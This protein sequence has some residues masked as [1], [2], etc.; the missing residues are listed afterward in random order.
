MAAKV[1]ISCGQASPPERQVAQSLAT[2]LT[3][4]GFS[5]YVAIQVQSILDLNAGIIG[6]LKSSDY[7]LFIN[8]RRD[9]LR[10]F[11]R[12]EYRGSLFA[13]QELSIAYALA[14]EHMLMLN[15]KAVRR[16]GVFQFMV[17]NIPDFT[18][19]GDVLGLVQDAVQ[20]AH[21]HS[22]YTR[23]LSIAGHYF[24]AQPFPYRDHTGE[25]H[26]RA[27]HV[28]I[29]NARP[30]RGAVE[31][32][33]RLFN[34]TDP[35]GNALQSPDRS[36]LKATRHPGY[37]QTIW[38]NSEGTYDLL[39]LDMQNQSHVYLLSELDV[40]PRAAIITQP[41][42]WLLDYEVFSQGFPRLAFR[43]QLNLTGTHSSTQAAITKL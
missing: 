12:R 32:I 20:T 18:Q 33:V 1:F 31:T 37:S 17:S 9:R 43:V 5:P 3:S 35:V 34:I 23:H 7:Y 8:F 38:P 29:R 42:T 16:E 39:A 2:W 40:H 25:R 41:G 13:N 27:L 30:D 15:Q 21:W 19:Y 36:Q 11:P 22:D 6:E 4:Q 24:T 14:F 10:L 28:R 26:I